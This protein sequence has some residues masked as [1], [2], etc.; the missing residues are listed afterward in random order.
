MQIRVETD[1]LI[2]ISNRLHQYRDEFNTLVQAMNDQ[3][4]IIPDVWAGHAADSFVDQWEGLKPTFVQVEE[5][6][7][8]IGIQTAEVVAAMEELDT[9]IA[10]VFK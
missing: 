8:T 1:Q 2:D 9:N 6:I 7:D 5:L 4:N 3:I 10:G